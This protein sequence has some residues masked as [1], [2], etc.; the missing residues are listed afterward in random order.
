MS[1]HGLE[2]SV[3]NPLPIY[4]RHASIY[5]PHDQIRRRLVESLVGYRPKAMSKAVEPQPW[6]L[7]PQ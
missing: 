3:A 2:P 7:E 6:P 4:R 1:H 5:L